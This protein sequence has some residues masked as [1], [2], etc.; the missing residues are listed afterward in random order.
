MRIASTVNFGANWT[1]NVFDPASLG[2]SAL[3]V[4]SP[5]RHHLLVGKGGEVFGSDDNGASWQVI[6]SRSAGAVVAVSP[7]P[8]ASPTLFLAGENV[9]TLTYRYS[10][11]N[12]TKILEIT[13]DDLDYDTISSGKNRQRILQVRSVGES[14]VFIDSVVITTMGATPDSAFR[15]TIPLDDV[16]QA[17]SAD[18]M[19]IRC[20]GTDLGR[21]DAI[22]TVYTNATPPTVTATLTA[23][24]ES[25]VSV[26]EELLNEGFVIAPNPASNTFL[27]TLPIAAEISLVDLS[28]RVIGTWNHT[29]PGTFNLDVSTHPVGSYTMVIRTSTGVRAL[30]VQIQR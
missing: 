29:D 16:I 28:G 12:G 1:A 22:V 7:E 18:Q 23:F 15:I 20:Y 6:L 2:I 14:D 4:S 21:Y 25:T 9:S 27:V 3:S 30:R 19:A 13:N 24:I 26:N 10:G 17:G 8:A 11:P 5:G